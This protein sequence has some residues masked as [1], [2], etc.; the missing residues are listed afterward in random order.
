[1]DEAQFAKL[2]EAVSKAM[3][4]THLGGL[5]GEVLHEHIRGMITRLHFK[6]EQKGTERVK[7]VLDDLEK[8]IEEHLVIK[9]GSAEEKAVKMLIRDHVLLYYTM[10]SLLLFE[11]KDILE[12]EDF[13]K[14]LKKDFEKK[15]IPK[16]T[17]KFA[18]KIFED[19]IKA[20]REE[21]VNLREEINSVFARAKGRTGWSL[22]FFEKM[23]SADGFFLRFKE[24]RLFGQT[25]RDERLIEKNANKL[26]SVKSKEELERILKSF[27]EETQEIV[28]DFVI[29]H[30]VQMAT[31]DELT[32][33]MNRLVEIVAKAA[34]I[35]ELP[36]NDEQE[37]DQLYSLINDKL[38]EQYLHAL[39]I[40]VKQLEAII[41]E[42]DDKVKSDVQ[43]L[44]A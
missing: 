28:K 22:G 36:L 38:N 5:K 14:K 40:D 7:G 21:I 20:W 17:A 9:A 44:A 19:A 41:A 18:I 39:R 10:H 3:G 32:Q 8:D 24:R 4:D 29:I 23:H 43:R 1:M 11:K 33:H 12:V 26:A 37:M 15:G 31:W 16:D 34:G 2:K 13:A 27:G 30:K 42:L 25:L 35:H 6:W